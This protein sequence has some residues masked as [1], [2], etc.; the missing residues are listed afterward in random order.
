LPS[1][2]VI[3]D[4]R[5][6]IYINLIYFFKSFI[7]NMCLDWLFS[8]FSKF[9]KWFTQKSCTWSPFHRKFKKKWWTN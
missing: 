3:I 6:V 2:K 9:G 4:I 5:I 8:Y 1:N 7:G